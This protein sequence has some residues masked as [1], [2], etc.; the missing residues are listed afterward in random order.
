MFPIEH[1]KQIAQRRAV[2]RHVR[3]RR[4]R[5]RLGQVVAA[6]LGDRRQAPVPLDEFIQRN[7]VVVHVANF[8]VVRVR[9]NNEQWDAGAVAEEI[10]RLHVARII[11]AA[12]FI[13]RD[14]DRRICTSLTIFSVK[15]SNKSSFDDAG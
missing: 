13:E 3:A 12:A 14:E 8:A 2:R 10:H 15:P 5:L 4:A 1:S 6:A 7:V 11:V 9:R